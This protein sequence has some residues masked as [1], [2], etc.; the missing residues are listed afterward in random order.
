VRAV[1]L[2]DVD[3]EAEVDGAVVDAVGLA[4]DL[5]KWLAITGSS[6]AAR[7]IAIGDQVGEGDLEAGVLELAA[8]GVE[9]CSRDRAEGS[10][11][12]GSSGSR[13]CSERASP[14]RP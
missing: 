3:G 2:L 9:L 4:V 5:A 12:S 11:R 6:V 8:A 13:P 14:H 7:A 10:S 1:L